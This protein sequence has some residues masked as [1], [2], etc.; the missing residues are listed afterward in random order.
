[1]LINQERNQENN[2]IGSFK[3][4]LPEGYPGNLT[5]VIGHENEYNQN[6]N[7]PSF[8]FITSKTKSLIYSLEMIHDD[9]DKNKVVGAKVIAIMPYSATNRALFDLGDNL[10]NLYH[11]KEVII[12]LQDMNNPIISSIQTD[13]SGEPFGFELPD[14]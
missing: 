13:Y 14:R 12:Y 1:M 3:S 11:K 9:K 4:P 10:C 8:V 7:A 5:D 2:T 6:K